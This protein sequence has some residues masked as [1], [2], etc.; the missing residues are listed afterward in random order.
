MKIVLL[1]D[2]RIILDGIGGYINA[3][4]DME[5]V[6][7]F[8]NGREAIHFLQDNPCDVMVLDVQMPDLNGRDV[9]EIVSRDH[10][11]INMLTL[12]MSDGYDTIREMHSLGV[13]GYLLK[14]SSRQEILD[15]IRIIHSGGT[16]F[17]QDVAQLLLQQY[18]RSDSRKPDKAIP[19][20]PREQEVLQLVVKEFSNSEI[21]ETLF[22][23]P[24]TVEVH[25]R[26]LLEKTQSKTIAGLV[27]FAIENDLL[28]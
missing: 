17:G 10:P 27:F 25:K 24:R 11:N 8:D 12:T 26:N 22:I 19:L 15:A 21:A 4:H 2:H 3:A 1:D 9:A 18:K 13:Q 5:L 16:Y 28:S 6:G 7:S 23:S 14:S 20:T